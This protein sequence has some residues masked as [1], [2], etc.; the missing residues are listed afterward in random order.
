MNQGGFS[1]QLRNRLVLVA[2]V[3]LLAAC[4]SVPFDYPKQASYQGKPIEKGALA[5]LDD[6]WLTDAP[7]NTAVY[8]LAD[9]AASFDASS[10]WP[11][12]QRRL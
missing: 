10:I 9:G 3:M 11:T 2:S 4:T 1:I 8:P 6:I 5:T 7:Q 12:W